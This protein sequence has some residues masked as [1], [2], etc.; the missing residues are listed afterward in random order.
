MGVL[1]RIAVGTGSENRRSDGILVSIKLNA[2][3]SGPMLHGLASTRLPHLGEMVVRVTLPA[4]S[5]MEPT[6]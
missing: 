2:G 1:P 3:V 6:I 5:R 4:V